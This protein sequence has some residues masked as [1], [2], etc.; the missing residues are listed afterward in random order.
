MA[1]SSSGGSGCLAVM[2]AL[3]LIALAIYAIAF[4][5]CVAVG[6]GLWF[7]IRYTWRAFP[8]RTPIQPSLNRF[9]RY[10]QWEGPRLQPSRVLF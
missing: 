3:I 10:P 4:A 9:Q 2:C 6:V 5:A 1:K 8:P 7:L